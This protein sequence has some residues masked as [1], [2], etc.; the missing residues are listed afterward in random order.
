MKLMSRLGDMVSPPVFF[1]SLDLAVLISVA[2]VS[3]T[4]PSSRTACSKLSSDGMSWS[5][6]SSWSNRSPG[7]KIS[8]DN[9]NLNE[10]N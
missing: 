9:E 10:N 8:H 7:V 3:A 1:D 4:S 5:G 6:T 2:A